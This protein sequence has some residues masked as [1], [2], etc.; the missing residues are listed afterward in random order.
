MKTSITNKNKAWNHFIIFETIE[1]IIGFVIVSHY[2]LNT[3][4][5]CILGSIMLFIGT[6]LYYP[7]IQ[8]INNFSDNTKNPYSNETRDDTK[9]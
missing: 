4:Q 6:I 8:K 9:A 2:D 5:I 7:K 1:L 3:V